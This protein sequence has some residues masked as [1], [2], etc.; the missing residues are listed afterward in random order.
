MRIDIKEF[1][2]IK[3]PLMPLKADLEQQIVALEK[4]K[5]DPLEPLRNWIL[6]AN[7]AEKAA[8]TDNWLE[9]KSFL[10]SVGS[11]RL[12]R[13]QTLT[14]EFKKTFHFLTETTIANRN[15][16]DVSEQCSRWWR[17]RELNP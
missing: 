11:N 12:L 5:T 14:V 13:Y 15:T 2:E 4:S 7:K 9:M 6:V 1:K 8:A 10:Q 16:S 3:N 17:R